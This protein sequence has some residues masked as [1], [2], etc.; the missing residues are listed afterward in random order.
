MFVVG[1]GFSDSV[2]VVLVGEG[3][4]EIKVGVKPISVDPYSKRQ[5]S[6]CDFFCNKIGFAYCTESEVETEV[7]L[8]VGKID[9]EV[10]VFSFDSCYLL[11]VDVKVPRLT[12]KC[13]FIVSFDESVVFIGSHVVKDC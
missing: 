4:I 6:I 11:V 13:C 8:F 9:F 10:G 5:V 3:S 2:G 12:V 1:F 7:V